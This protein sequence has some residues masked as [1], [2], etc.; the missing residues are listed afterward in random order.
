MPRPRKENLS[1]FSFDADFFQDKK[2]KRLRAQFGADG[3]VVYQYIL[4]AIYSGRG[5]YTEFDEDLVLDIS[6]YFHFTEQKTMQ[7]LNYLFSRSLLVKIESTL[8]VPVKVISALSVQRRYQEAKREAKREIVVDERFWLL[9]KEETKTFIKV[10]SFESF[11]EKNEDKSEKNDSKSGIYRQSKVKES[12][13]KES[14][15]VLRLPCRNGEF[16]VDEDLLADLTHTYP[17]MDVRKSLEKLCSYLISK[18][19]KQGYVSSA[20]GYLRMWLADDDR[21]GKY[22]KKQTDTYEGSYDLELYESTSV[23]DELEDDEDNT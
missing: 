6:D 10:R 14:M 5:Y 8:P 7:I 13:V 20:E 12:K 15:C 17:D 3:I 23:I 18:P 1:Y 9:K 22:R 19:G 11:S 21:E 2:I 16:A 4:C